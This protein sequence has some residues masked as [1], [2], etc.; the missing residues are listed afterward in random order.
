MRWSQGYCSIEFEK[1]VQDV[2]INKPPEC[3]GCYISVY[4]TVMFAVN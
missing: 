4:K 3:F 1:P 2:R